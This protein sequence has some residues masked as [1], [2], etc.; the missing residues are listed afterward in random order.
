MHRFYLPPE[1][2]HGDLLRLDGREAHHALHVLRLKRGERVTVLNGAGG[3]LLCDVSEAAKNFLSLAVKEKKFTPPP[4]CAITLL[5]GIP[6]GKIIESIIQKSVELGAQKIVPLLT[7]RTV[8]QL[9]GDDAGDKR[10]KWQQVAIEAIKQCGAS[11]LPKVET[12]QTIAEFLARGEKLDLALVGS[13]QTERKHPR[14]WI[15]EFQKSYGHLPESAAVWIGP[16]GDFTLEELRAIEDSGAK[17]M[18]LG[19][20]TL[21]VE[22]AAIYCL[23]FLNYQLQRD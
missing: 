16:E 15:S 19:R 4:D 9:D 23:A 2:C 21:R 22:T 1:N 18:T 10:E 12:P 7:A 8:T 13:L 20:L 17:P 14:E 6:K 3:E 11:W 5:V